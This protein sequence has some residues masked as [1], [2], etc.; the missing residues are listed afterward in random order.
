M[1]D[2]YPLVELHRHLD[3]NVRIETV[4]DLARQ[5]GLELPAWT[6]EGLRP[7]VQITER[8]PSLMAFIAKFALLR[9][10]MA[11]YDAVRR[12]ARE[13]LEDAA[14]EGIDYIELRFSPYF[15]GEE[16]GLDTAGV[17]EA[18][19]DALEEARGTIPVKAKLIGII[20]RHYGPEIGRVELAAAIRGRDRGVVALDL[21]GD[22]ANFPGELFVRH[23]AEA[24]EAGLRAVAH[25]GEA[26]GASSVRQAVLELGAERIGHGVRAVEDAAVLD[27]LAERRVALEVCPTSNV[28][29]S[30]VASY[31]SHP[32]PA[33]LRRGLQVTLNT[34]DPGIS[35]IDLAHEYRV[36][37]E[38]LGLSA[39]ELR[40]LQENAVAAAFLTPEE[41]AELLAGYTSSLH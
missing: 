3:G 36:A 25:A 12:I 29:T 14:R 6:V 31:R 8:E 34:D 27:L 23:F 26:A 33:F 28:Q 32:L 35:G 30:T 39:A 2:G 22:E 41:R 40:R 21:A 1:H 17:V 15:M 37:A 9:R 18:A 7:H 38:E 4:L 5:H 20:S 19:C 13:N 10:V 16:H 11:D 24:R